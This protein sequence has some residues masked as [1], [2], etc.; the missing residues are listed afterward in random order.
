MIKISKKKSQITISGHAGYAE[1]GKDIVC[2]A[3]SMLIYNLQES[4]N[5]LTEDTVGFCFAQDETTIS[6]GT[7]S[8]E[9]QLL[10][11]SFIIGI[12]MLASNYPDNVR[13]D[14]A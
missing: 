6:F 1:K 9:T 10:I 12:K 5:R 2:A 14:Q 8:K 3:V 4:I 7:V 11:D 13:I